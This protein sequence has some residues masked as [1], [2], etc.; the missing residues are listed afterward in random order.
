MLCLTMPLARSEC[1]YVAIGGA[2]TGASHVL[3]LF[4]LPDPI[5]PELWNTSTFEVT[6]APSLEILR[7]RLKTYL[8]DESYPHI[9]AR[10][11]LLT[12]LFTA[13]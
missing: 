2:L 12:D 11:V 6:S 7:R 3:R 8:F 9:P 4:I 13:C 1:R 5:G 10:P